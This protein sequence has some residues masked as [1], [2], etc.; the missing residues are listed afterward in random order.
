MFNSLTAYFPQTY[1]NKN[2]IYKTKLAALTLR[3]LKEKKYLI[4]ED[5]SSSLDC[6]N[7]CKFSENFV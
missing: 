7:V 2:T 4:A 5:I 1:I 3:I 6:H